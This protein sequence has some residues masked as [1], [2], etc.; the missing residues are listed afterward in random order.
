MNLLEL[1][2]GLRSVGAEA[3]KQGLN[4]FSVDW[5]LILMYSGF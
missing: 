2:A 1:F 3:E 5:K 4:V